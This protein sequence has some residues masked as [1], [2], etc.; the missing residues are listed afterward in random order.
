MLVVTRRSQ[1][2]CDSVRC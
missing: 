1:C 2:C